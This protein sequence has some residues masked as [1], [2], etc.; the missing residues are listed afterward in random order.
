MAT[1]MSPHPLPEFLFQSLTGFGEPRSG[2]ARTKGST[3][4]IS[5]AVHALL[6]AAIL[7]VPLFL[8]DA[9][10]EPSAAI[11][12][13]F[14][15]APP[16]IA[17]A[18]PPPPP[19]PPAL[20]NAVKSPV[21][22]PSLAP[23]TFVAP[24]EAPTGIR[25]EASLDLGLGVEGGVPGGVE[26]G[27]PGGVVGG[28]VGGALPEAPPAVKVV[29]VGGAITAPKILKRVDPVYPDLAKAARLGAVIV[30]EARV[31]IHGGVKEVSVLR[32]NPLFDEAATEAV[33]Q[34]RYRPLLLNGE[35]TEFILTVTVIFNI[36]G[37][38]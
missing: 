1:H 37:K 7:I 26:G 34:W 5:V 11:L 33:K 24:I 6:V 17:P 35:P 31:D 21:P 13:A 36:Q 3:L 19:P 23:A 25:P 28:I 30:M 22:V 27:V 4:A 8:Y 14:F 10:P 15:V 12:K 29:R 2:S 16:E 20:R 32:G 38:N 18:P 9:I